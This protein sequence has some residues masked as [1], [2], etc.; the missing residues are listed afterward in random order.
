M[1]RPCGRSRLKRQVRAGEID[2]EYELRFA[3]ASARYQQ[4]LRRG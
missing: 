2:M 4:A 1:G 3:A